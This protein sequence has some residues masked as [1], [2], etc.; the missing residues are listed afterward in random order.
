LREGIKEP[1]FHLLLAM[2]MCS[3]FSFLYLA[4]VYKTIGIQVGGLD[5]YTL[6]V[7]GSLGGLANGLSRVFWGT[8]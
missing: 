6:T 8:M 3:I 1:Q 7:I 4:S 5:D 2:D